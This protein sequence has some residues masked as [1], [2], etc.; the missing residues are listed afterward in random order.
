[1]E[2]ASRSDLQILD[3]LREH[4][5]ETEVGPGVYDIHSPR[6]P[7]VEE[8]VKALK[9]MLTKIDKEKLWVVIRQLADCFPCRYKICNS[10]AIVHGA[11]AFGMSDPFQMR[12]AV[13]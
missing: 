7:S 11:E 12:Q 13:P 8:I 2:E 3:S 9:L 5:F 1:M 10:N 4:H 6:V